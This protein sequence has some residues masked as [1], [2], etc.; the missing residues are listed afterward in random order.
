MRSFV[1]FAVCALLAAAPRLGSADQ[2]AAESLYRQATAETDPQKR[3]SLLEASIAE[4]ET[5]EARFALGET[6]VGLARHEPARDELR[7]ALQIAGSDKARARATYLVAETFLGEGNQVDA[8]PLLYKALRLHA[9]PVIV[10]RLKEI[11]RK[12]IDQPVT[13]SEITRALEG[14]ATRAFGVKPSVNLRI[15]FDFDSASLTSQG[16]RQA[17]ELG[18]ALESLRGGSFE[19]VGHTDRQGDEA[20]NDRLSLRRAET[21]KAFLAEEFGIPSEALTA[22]G[23]GERDLLYPGDTEEDHALNRRVEVAVH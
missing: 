12:R 15:G 6:L 14:S 13:A 3:I 4:Y 18:R 23:R 1:T 17:R 8:L 5:F 9:Y 7:R 21:V 2:Q 16:E 20:Y 22:T 19:I 10:E 11:E